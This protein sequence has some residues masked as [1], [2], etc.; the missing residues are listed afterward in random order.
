MYF[1]EIQN[2][3]I[4]HNKIIYSTTFSLICPPLWL[5]Q[6]LIFCKQQPEEFAWLQNF[7]YSDKMYLTMTFT[8]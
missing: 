8:R 3:I 1:Q 7:R 6:I 5:F 2:R 4:S